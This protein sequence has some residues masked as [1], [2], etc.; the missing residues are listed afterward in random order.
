MCDK[1]GAEDGTIASQAA[2][3]YQTA[4]LPE[5]E[6]QQS[7]KVESRSL[8]ISTSEN[9]GAGGIGFRQRSSADGL[10]SSVGACE[11]S[12]NSL[13]TSETL[14]ALVGKINEQSLDRDY[15]VT[16][17]ISED[18]ASQID[19]LANQFKRTIGEPR[20]TLI[21]EHLQSVV[22]F[23]EHG[24]DVQFVNN[25]Y[26]FLLNSTD[27]IAQQ[28]DNVTYNADEYDPLVDV[29][30]NYVPKRSNHH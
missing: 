26:S 5:E 1:V 12:S 7:M 21:D 30:V 19:Y 18:E 17:Y 28:P 25:F 9:E 23:F 11:S 14:R 2:L 13:C 27:S 10:I 22:S 6:P 4:L 20:G 3:L 15:R 29:I 8:R 24:G 16:S